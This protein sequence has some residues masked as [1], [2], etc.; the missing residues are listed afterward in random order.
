MNITDLNN[1]LFQASQQLSNI[2]NIINNKKEEIIN[3]SENIINQYVL[4]NIRGNNK[5]INKQY[6]ELIKNKNMENISIY[7]YSKEKIFLLKNN[8]ENIEED[9]IYI[10]I[11]HDNKNYL[12]NKSNLLKKYKNWKIFNQKEI[13]DVIDDE[14]NNSEISIGLSNIK[15]KEQEEIKDI[16]DKNNLF[17]YVNNLPSKKVYNI[18][19]KVKIKRIPKNKKLNN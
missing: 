19:Y 15:I 11:I 14:F 17:D 3:A 13:I 6:L 7:D 10:E 18:K 4:I 9:N 1:Y 2:M 8:L 12:V 16:D 5:F